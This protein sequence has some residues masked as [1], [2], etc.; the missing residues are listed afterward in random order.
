MYLCVCVCVCA[1][2]FTHA[3]KDYL[4]WWQR[5]IFVEKKAFTLP[6]VCHLLLEQSVNECLC[7]TVRVSMMWDH[8]DV[9]KATKQERCVICQCVRKLQLL[10]FYEHSSLYFICYACLFWFGSYNFFYVF[11][12]V[13]LS[14]CLSNSKFRL[15]LYPCFLLSFPGGTVEAV[16]ILFLF[17][18]EYVSKNVIFSQTK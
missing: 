12:S 6:D 10:K 4:W 13:C 11:L 3:I 1:R 15:P 14:V 5:I 2:E 9:P 16:K 17:W 8:G 18:R 7:L